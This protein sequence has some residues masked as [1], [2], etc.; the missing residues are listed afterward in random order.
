MLTFQS[1]T[2]RQATWLELFFDLVFVAVI[3]VLAHKLDHAH[4]GEI[5]KEQ[6]LS[7]FL[8]FIPLWWVWAGHTLYA[9][10]YDTDSCL[11]RY[12]AICLMALIVAI[13]IF[14]GSALGSGFK[15]FVAVYLLMRCVISFAYYCAPDTTDAGNKLAKK[16]YQITLVGLLVSSGSLFF[17]SD[18]KF[19][20]LYLGIVVEVLLMHG[21]R[22]LALDFPVHRKHLI[23]RIGLLAI[24][25]LG[26]SLISIIRTLSVKENYEILDI[27]ATLGG[28]LLIVQ[29]WWIYFDSLYL[30]ERAK[31]IKTGL[32]P[33]ISNL[34]LYVGIIFLASL[35]GHAISGDLNSQTF[36]MLGLSGLVLFYIGKQ[37]PYFTAYPPYRISK[38]ANTLV[39]VSITVIAT[40]L[41]QAEYSLLMMCLGIFVYVQLNLRWTIPLHNIDEYIVTEGA[42]E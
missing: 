22:K 16:M 42:G 6:L 30:L 7:F 19:Y 8:I 4:H 39:C 40:L 41:P 11:N 17:T 20:L 9:N 12:F 10:R 33:L 29:I 34:F 36:S 18:V 23:E 37:A 3:G 25:V 21:T 31:N 5:G 1:K 35:T 13:S 24:I 26:E 2:V 38:V 14:V 28:F 15:G 27:V 32:T